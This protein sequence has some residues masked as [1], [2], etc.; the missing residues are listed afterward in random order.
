MSEAALPLR[1]PHGRGVLT[2][3]V[4]GSGV[5]FLDTTVVNVALPTL[6]RALGTG[7][8]GLQW[9]VDAYLLMLSALLLVGG[10]L[11][12]RFGRRRVYSAGLL[13]FGIASALCG[14]SNRMDALI[15]ARALQGVGGA[16]LVPGSLSL[17]RAVIREDDQGRA[18]GLWS[19]LSG[20]TTAI[21]PLAGGWLIEVVSWRAA[22]FINLPLIAVA[23]WA[24]HHFCPESRDEEAKAKLDVAGAAL[25]TLGLG[26]AVFAL[27]EGPARG[28]TGPF[29]AA[30]AASAVTLVAFLILEHRRAA[31]M[32]PL[33]I[34]RSLQFVGANATTLGMYFA[35]GGATF[36]V[37]IH[38]QRS[39]GYSPLAAG[40]SLFPLTVLM[41]VL[42]PVAGRLTRR[43][44]H[45]GL[46]TAGPLIAACGLL[47]FTRIGRAETWWTG[48]FPGASVLGLGLAT[49]VAPLTDAALS[50]APRRHAGIASGVNNAVARIAGL[51]AVAVLP[52]AV[53]WQ[54]AATAEAAS[55]ALGFDRAMWTCAALSALAGLLA[56]LTIDRA[57]PAG[58]A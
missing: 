27:I 28:W 20:V 11:G 2:T 50:G 49:T 4:L 52:G 18:I 29:I 15:A 51:L 1:S 33:S 41:L 39:A 38:L 35:L 25:A 30:A 17:I 32:L 9:V 8:S 48:V 55:I 36:F 34:F 44:G 12:D 58:S 45:R 21:G 23:L 22:F 42:S 3:A 10:A 24:L 46:M 19:G 54:Q 16:L 40:A 47:L 56:F 5:A 37:V 14:L 7:M 53:G 31:P 6:E 43:W 13:L 26:G 57:S